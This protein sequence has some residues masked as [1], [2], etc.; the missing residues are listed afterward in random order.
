MSKLL[1]NYEA[2]EKI[3]GYEFKNK[4]LLKTAFT[5]KS[6]S[7]EHKGQANYERLEF[8]GDSILGFFVTDYLYRSDSSSEGSLSAKKSK[9][10]SSI[11]L[12]TVLFNLGL[13]KYIL[14]GNGFRAEVNKK[15]CE[16]VFE[17]LIAAIYLDGGVSKAWSFVYEMLIDSPYLESSFELTK[18]YK[19]IIKEFIEKN[20]IGELVYK[21]INRSGPEHNLTFMVALVLNG[22]EI[23]VGEGHS[24]QKAEQDAAKIAVHKLKERGYKLEF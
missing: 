20:H 18:D 15:F 10:V 22:E 7:N 21:E 23:S 24:L 19:S 13:D 2:V 4:D 14:F 6:Y 16:D 3:I 12:A 1:F 17:A 5:H 9:L 8:L 11:P